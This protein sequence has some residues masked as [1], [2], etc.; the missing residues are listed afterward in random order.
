MIKIIVLLFLQ[1]LFECYIWRGHHE[2]F[3]YRVG[4]NLLYIFCIAAL[5]DAEAGGQIA[6]DCRVVA[7]TT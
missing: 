6:F 2:Y 4:P 3:D 5:E 7:V 1:K